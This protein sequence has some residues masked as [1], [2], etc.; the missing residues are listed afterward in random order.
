VSDSKN[1]REVLRE[2]SDVQVALHALWGS[3]VG[4]SGY[5]KPGWIDLG[6]AID[7]LGRTA[8]TMAGHPADEPLV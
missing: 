1:A 8:A 6:N 2:Y 7:R 4:L 5:H 3:F